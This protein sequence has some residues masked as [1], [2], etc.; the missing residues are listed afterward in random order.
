[1]KVTQAQFDELARVGTVNECEIVDQVPPAAS[2]A[3]PVQVD[4]V[5]EAPVE[6]AP[7]ADQEPAAVV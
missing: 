5:V 2:E 7:P 1:M 3:T 6:V 4:T